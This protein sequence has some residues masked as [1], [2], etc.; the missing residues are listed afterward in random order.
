[1]SLVY[2]ACRRLVGRYLTAART[3]GDR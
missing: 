2:I 1:L 3:A